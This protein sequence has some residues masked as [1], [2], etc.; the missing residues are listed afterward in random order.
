MADFERCPIGTK[1]YL[2]DAAKRFREYETHHRDIAQRTGA[3]TGREEKAARNAEMAERAE[4]LLR[5]F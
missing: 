3:K 4:Q 5:D 2:E 1:T